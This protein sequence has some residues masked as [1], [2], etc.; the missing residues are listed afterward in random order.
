MNLSEQADL[1]VDAHVHPK[2]GA[3]AL[4]AEM[5]AAGVTYAVLLAVDTD[6]EDIKRPDL[7]RQT[8]FRFFRT[9]EAMRVFWSEVEASWCR[10]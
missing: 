8:R 3:E 1:V 9:P 6:P 2:M 7:R 10:S 5:D 4:L